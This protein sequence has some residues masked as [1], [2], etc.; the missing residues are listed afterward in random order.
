[1][2]GLSL[3]RVSRRTHVHHQSAHIRS[4]AGR[5]RAR[6]RCLST[7]RL[8][9]P[10]RR[11]RRP[12][13]FLVLNN[14]R[15][16]NICSR[17]DTPSRPLRFSPSQRRRDAAPACT[18]ILSFDIYLYALLYDHAAINFKGSDELL[19]AAPRRPAVLHTRVL[20]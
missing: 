2:C 13:L 6:L 18:H 15:V 12:C 3:C 9:Q 10:K 5:A 16:P 20:W 14:A 19:D 7:E 1:M 17:D 8:Q 4:A 11:W